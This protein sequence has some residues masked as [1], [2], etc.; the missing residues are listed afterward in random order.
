MNKSKL[1]ATC[2]VTLLVV[3]L[4]V[5]VQPVID[6]LRNTEDLL[7]MVGLLTVCFAVVTVCSIL[8]IKLEAV[9]GRLANRDRK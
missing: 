9:R 5:T 2:L 4:G 7:S 8:K 3:V 1:L 6:L